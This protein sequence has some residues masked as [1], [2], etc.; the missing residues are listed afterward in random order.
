MTQTL[1]TLM[2]MSYGRRLERNG[3]EEENPCLFLTP[4]SIFYL[5][6]LRLGSWFIFFFYLLYLFFTFFVTA[7]LCVSQC[8]SFH[9][10]FGCLCLTL[11][12]VIL[13]Q[14][15]RPVWKGMVQVPRCPSWQVTFLPAGRWIRDELSKEWTL[16]L[17]YK[18]TEREGPDFWS[19]DCFVKSNITL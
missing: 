8:G 18:V 4:W 9:K 2:S 10:Y 16:A 5:P 13:H 6:T 19:G 1:E 3:R 12:S 17:Q 11:T 7:A 14:G 15:H